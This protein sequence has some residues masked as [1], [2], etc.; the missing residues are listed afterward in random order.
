MF[1]DRFMNKVN[2]Q[3]RTGFKT[4]IELKTKCKTILVSPIDVEKVKDRHPSLRIGKSNVTHQTIKKDLNFE[5]EVKIDNSKDFK[6]KLFCSQIFES[7]FFRYDSAGASHKN[8]DPDIPLKE[9]QITTP[10]F[11]EFNS[12]GIEIAYKTKALLSASQLPKL[13]DINVCIMHFC[14][15]GNMRY[16]KSDFPEVN[17]QKGELGFKFTNDDPLKNVGF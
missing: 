8:N 11:H 7:P 4:Y 6:F 3:I 14:E 13:E 10:H 9:Q 5:V 16:Q 1:K 2:N 17:L 15:E 12:K